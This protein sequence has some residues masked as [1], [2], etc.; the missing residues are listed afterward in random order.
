MFKINEFLECVHCPI[1]RAEHNFLETGPFLIL[2]CKD[3]EAPTWLGL[4]LSDSDEL[5]LTD[6]V[7]CVHRLT[8][9]CEYRKRSSF[10][11]SWKL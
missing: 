9:S 11:K 1:L 3:D 5:Y 10:L 8:F 7:K 2:R 4:W 6:P